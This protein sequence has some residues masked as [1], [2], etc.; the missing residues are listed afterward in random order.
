MDSIRI[1]IFSILT[2]CSSTVNGSLN[3][4]SD[5]KEKRTPRQSGPHKRKLIDRVGDRIEF[6]LNVKQ[7][8]R[9]Y[10]IWVALDLF[11]GFF[12]IV[13]S[14]LCGF[15]DDS[16]ILK[17]Q[18]WDLMTDSFRLFRYS[19]MLHKILVILLIE[20][21]VFRVRFIIENMST[22]HRR[23]QY[24]EIVTYF[25][26]FKLTLRAIL[27]I[28]GLT[29]AVQCKDK[30]H[31][32]KSKCFNRKDS[33]DHGKYTFK[34]AKNETSNKKT[35]NMFHQRHVELND[36]KQQR[37]YSDGSYSEDFSCF[38]A[39]STNSSTNY[40]VRTQYE[41]G[42]FN[43][44]DGFREINYQLKF[45]KQLV[46]NGTV[47][48]I[49][50]ATFKLFVRFCLTGTFVLFCVLGLLASII[51]LVEY[52]NCH[53]SIITFLEKRL[54]HFSL[55]SYCIFILTSQ[56]VDI[57][58]FLCSCAVCHNKAM[59]T[60]NCVKRTL[61][62]LYRYNRKQTDIFI[63][64]TAIHRRNARRNAGMFYNYSV[65]PLIVIENKVFDDDRIVRKALTENHAPQSVNAMINRN[66]TE[67]LVDFSKHLDTLVAMIM[68]LRSGFDQLKQDFTLY[69]N[70][71]LIFK[72][73]CVM[74]TVA[75]LITMPDLDDLQY[76]AIL[77]IFP[78]YWI[79]IVYI[80]FS[81][82]LIHNKVT[83]MT[84]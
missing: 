44:D 9:R 41:K 25:A 17:W 43:F 54:F 56:L 7:R 51:L 18:Q 74:F 10:L 60:L 72:M 21:Y 79:P 15:G 23:R 30:L 82:A 42:L 40:L 77:L 26:S 2:F 32:D 76:T 47:H 64:T 63:S 31:L 62:D 50:I 68:E 6:F 16:L 22:N 29:D 11:S 19:R 70:L 49:E 35:S 59:Y 80:C 84:S 57:G 24:D 28:Y 1:N 71:E 34:V 27:Y 61:T 14:I 55:A 78:G 52:H 81:V 36:T 69:F 4:L 3:L 20:T 45:P 65:E 75:T 8:K 66:K 67:N 5:K 39:K 83:I 58:L 73:P 37:Q 33:N 12:F 38:N 13:N 46:K 53:N 48:L